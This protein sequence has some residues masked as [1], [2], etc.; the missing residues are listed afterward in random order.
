MQSGGPYTPY[1]TKL[2]VVFP[3]SMGISNWPGMSY[4]PKLGY[5]FINT[6]NLGDVAKLANAEPGADPAYQITSPWGHFARFWNKEKYWPCQ[7][8]PWG[9][10]WAIDV[11]T[12]DV[13]WK[14]P[15][16]RIKELEEK[17]VY[18]TG[19]LNMGG[20]ITTGGGLL[21][22]AATDDQIFRAF[23]AKTGKVL[24]ST[25]LETGAYTTPMTY[26]A[27]NGK[28]YV[29]LVATGGGYY[30]TTSGDSVIAFALP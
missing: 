5:L 29:V 7:K 15:F 4:N 12:G 13:A 1:G 21:F 24:W 17:G 11:N 3:G 26:R 30:D 6:V 10:L 8:P 20:S 16:G 28:Q 18:G 14:R 25:K 9:Q 19:A 27:K 23:D 2:T 22:I